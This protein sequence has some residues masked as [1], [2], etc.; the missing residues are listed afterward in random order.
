MLLAEEVVGEVRGWGSGAN[1]RSPG[2]AILCCGREKQQGEPCH[3]VSLFL[4]GGG[5]QWWVS[6]YDGRQCVDIITHPAPPMRILSLLNSH[7]PPVSPCRETL[8]IPIRSLI[9]ES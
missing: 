2:P 9:A 7:I 4:T 8:I 3:T 1:Q 5:G 6:A